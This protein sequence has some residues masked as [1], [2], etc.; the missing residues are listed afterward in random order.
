M[1]TAPILLQRCKDTAQRCVFYVSMVPRLTKVY[2]EHTKL[3][4]KGSG[5][6][7][8]IVESVM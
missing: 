7:Q 5:G 4:K 3:K 1:K 8:S 2:N 6:S